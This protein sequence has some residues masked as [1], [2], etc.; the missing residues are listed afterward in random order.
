MKSKAVLAAAGAAIVGLVMLY[1]YMER[2][3]DEASGGE[4]VQVLIATQD[5]PLGS[6][7]SP[8]MVAVHEI[9]TA[10]IE[11]RHVL[12]ADHDRVMGVRIVSSVRAGESLLWTDLATTSDTSRDLSGLVRDGM[13][14]I[15]IE[16]DATASFG[17]LIRAGDRVDVLITLDRRVTDGRVG[18]S[19]D[20]SV[21]RVTVP[22]LQNLLVLAAGTN[23]GAPVRSTSGSSSA[24]S[25]IAQ[26]TLSA[27]LEQAQ[28]LAFA[29][30]RGRIT[31]TLR[32]VDDN[33]VY[34]GLT[35]TT[36]ADIIDEER[37]EAIV[38]S[39]P[40]SR[41][42]EATVPAGPVDLNRNP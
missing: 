12:A 3:E 21:E 41:P 5:I 23:M 16:A 27:T 34:E 30:R 15:T 17:G 33:R 7:L 42:A 8:N 2:F 4:P 22:M 36:T 31:L 38:R 24:S 39:R 6:S 26:V 18:T 14:A 40:R 28:L 35:E 1:L 32:Y 37:R 11:D 19:P 9:P 25:N 20:G 29:A 13:R 10:Y